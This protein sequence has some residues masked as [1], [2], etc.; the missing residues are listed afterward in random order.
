MRDDAVLDWFFPDPRGAPLGRDSDTALVLNLTLA[1]HMH[2]G[3]DCGA[4]T[5]EHT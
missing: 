4:K 3:A 2:T 5:C 1:M